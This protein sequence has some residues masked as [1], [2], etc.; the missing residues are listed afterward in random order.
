MSISHEYRHRPGEDGWTAV[1]DRG[2]ISRRSLAGCFGYQFL[3]KGRRFVRFCDAFNIPILTFG[4][5]AWLSYRARAGVRGIIRH[6]REV[7]L[8]LCRGDRSE[9][10][11]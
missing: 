7:A 2:L 11:P 3:R 10:L 5:C 8:R 9:K 1:G 4:G 6:W